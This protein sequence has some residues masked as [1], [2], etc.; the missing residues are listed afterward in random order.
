MIR[1]VVRTA[2]APALLAML[3]LVS[4]MPS[5]AQTRTPNSSGT[6]TSPLLTGPGWSDLSPGERQALL[7]LQAQWPG[8]DATRKQKWRDVAARYP[9]L[10]PVQQA[11]LHERMLEWATMTPTQ[12]NT[13][14]IS[15]EELRKL[16]ATERQTRW[17]AYQSLPAEQRQALITQAG[18]RPMAASAPQAAAVRKTPSV[19]TVQAKSSIVTAPRPAI[20]PQSVAPGT[21]LAGVG[22]STRP[23]S[24]PPTPPRHQQAGLPKIAAT[25]EFVQND[26]LLP[27]RGPQG[28]GAGPLTRPDVP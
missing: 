5:G 28:A 1:H 22:A 25:P 16:P 7:P 4:A 13:A 12:R 17:E 20:R 23:I 2:M 19:D 21:V 11:R 3:S 26:T 15:F 24:K 8:I 9:T 6:T 27:Q 10:P 14:R 18:N